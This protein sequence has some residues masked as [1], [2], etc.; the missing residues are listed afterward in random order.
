MK[1]LKREEVD[2]LLVGGGVFS[3]TLGALLIRAEPGLSIRVVER[4]EGPALEAS[5]AWNNAGTGH[6][7]LCE[8]NYTP[9]GSAG[10]VDISKALTIYEQFLQTQL[11]WAA[12]R[13]EGA[14]GDPRSFINSAPH[15]GFV[16][17]ARDVAFLKARHA[18]LTRHHF[19][20][21]MEYSEEPEQ[22]GRWAPLLAEGR[23][24]GL[25]AATYSSEGT[26]VDF[27]SV[28]SQLLRDFETR[29]G[30]VRCNQE[31]TS[32]SEN[33]DGSWTARVSSR[34]GDGGYEIRARRVF[35]G[36]GGWTLKLLRQAG[37]REVRGYGLLP[38]SGTFLASAEE[39]I[40]GQHQVK[41]YGKA[42]V[43]APPM[44]MP[45]MDA[46]VIEGKRSVLF[47]PFAGAIPKFLKQ[48]SRWDLVQS[49]RPDNIWRLGAM[50]IQNLN[51][52]TLLL[53]D[54]TADHGAKVD[55]LRE[56]MPS[57][58]EEE[59]HLITAGQRAQIVKPDRKCGGKLTFGT[60][61]I[62]SQ[63]GTIAGVLGASPGASTAV[64]IAVDVLERMFPQASSAS[65][66][67][68]LRDFKP[69]DG[70][71][72][73]ADPVAT[74]EFRGRIKVGLGL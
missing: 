59:W 72:L 42:P 26:D 64:P 2:V 38:V 48:G 11:F 56:F 52:V 41:V 68:R 45:H 22:I 65:W 49:L 31:I 9:R 54:L 23:N 6:A 43:G 69:A 16:R 15:M 18:A 30:D 28:A 5:S 73:V 61:I 47:G 25:V 33:T 62:S 50:G 53:R 46:R 12:L 8:L 24:K 60:E 55:A 3:A 13:E 10:G 70:R 67:R 29:G 44:S 71:N 51:L 32:I 40:T 27:G 35:A 7:G 19:F 37:L 74:A 4:L 20:S 36:A 21:D 14:L 17:G 34:E 66:Q 39:R 58:R 63:N 1:S 57:A